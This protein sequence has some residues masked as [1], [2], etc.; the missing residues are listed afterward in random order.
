MMKLRKLIKQRSFIVYLPRLILR[1]NS[2]ISTDLGNQYFTQ[3]KVIRKENGL[4]K[5]K[6]LTPKYN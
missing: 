2:A 1:R 4:T 5:Y 3:I 6:T